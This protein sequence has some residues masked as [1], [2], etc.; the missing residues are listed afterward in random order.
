MKKEDLAKVRKHFKTESERLRVD[1]IYNIVCKG[2]TFVELNEDGANMFD[3][4]DEDL[5]EKF[6]LSFK[7]IL[8][9]NFDSNLFNLKFRKNDGLNY[10]KELLSLRDN[11]L[12][13]K[14]VIELARKISENGS[15]GMDVLLTLLTATVIVPIKNQ[16]KKDEFDDDLDGYEYNVVMC[17]VSRLSP[18]TS[19]FTLDKA[20]GEIAI[21]RN[22]GLLDIKNPIEGFTY[23]SYTDG[24]IDVNNVLY[25]TNKKD[26]PNELFVKNV[27]GCERNL[28]SKIQKEVFTTIIK[29]AIG[30]QIDTN[31]LSKIYYD[32]KEQGEISGDDIIDTKII[33]KVLLNRGF[34]DETKIK[35]AISKTLKKENAELN[36]NNILPS[37]EIELKNSSVSIKIKPDK[38][39]TVVHTNKN[40]KRV[41]MIEL[42]DSIN[43]D[44]L[45]LGNIIK[46]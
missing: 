19:S 7:K 40:G 16:N 12:S 37:K 5:R 8:T 46:K 23:P 43:I 22:I 38:L 11:D 39:N 14:D 15:Y 1:N 30:E 2:D 41:L 13:K 28:T 42:D 24:F 31:T 32:I 29:T 25:Y 21:Y 45:T 20:T 4:L 10:Q 36:V 17:M 18:K 3:M 33:T 44:D 9:G 6:I 35:E 27:L 26:E 34:G